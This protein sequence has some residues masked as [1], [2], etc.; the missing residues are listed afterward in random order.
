LD[1]IEMGKTVVLTILGDEKA[2]RI[3]IMEELNLSIS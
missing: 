3:A 1:V 2:G